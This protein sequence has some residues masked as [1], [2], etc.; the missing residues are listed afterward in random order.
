MIKQ[1]VSSF[2]IV[3]LT[4]F[5]VFSITVFSQ[6]NEHSKTTIQGTITSL[7]STRPIANVDITVYYHEVDITK[8]N[9]PLI[10]SNKDAQEIVTL[11][12]DALGEFECTIPLRK[13]TDYVFIKITGSGYEPIT[14]NLIKIKPGDVQEHNFTLT[15]LHPT[16]EEE[17]LIENKTKTFRQQ[18]QIEKSL[19]LNPTELTTGKKK[20]LV[21]FGLS[22]QSS[23]SACSYLVPTSVFVSN[24]HNGYNG[25]SNGNGYTGYIDFDLYVAGVVH[26]EIGGITTNIE[27]K[28]AQAIAARTFSLNRHEQNLPVNIGQAYHDTPTESSSLGSFQSSEQVI[29]YN[30]QVIDAKYSAR[31]NGDYTQAATAGTWSPYTTCD[32]YGNEIP[33]LQSVSCSG[34]INCSQTSEIP[35]CN[36]TISTS[37]ELGYIYGH[38]VGMCQRGIEQFGEI[39][40]WSACQMLT[41]Y[42]TGVCIANTNCGNSSSTLICENA[43]PIACGQSY[44]GATSNATSNVY[45]YGCNNWTETGPERVHQITP[46]VSGILT[47]TISNFTGDLDVYLL[48]SCDPFDCLGTVY[49]AEVIFEH[50]IADSTYYIVVDADDGSGSGYNLMVQCEPTTQVNDKEKPNKITIYPNPTN[51]VLYVAGANN[52]NAVIVKNTQGKTV[53]T[54]KLTHGK[55]NLSSLAEGIY[56]VQILGEELQFSRTII[57]Q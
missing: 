10:T 13:V 5:M 2:K 22:A 19:D 28:K 26:G 41:N 53:L 38:G 43:I 35:C 29:L 36:A 51:D 31:C 50:A 40:G 46:S 14:K 12:S 24:L 21:K 32:T 48:G 47:A 30:N 55:I 27:T 20:A 39:F 6:N 3:M 56:L 9:Y 4:I 11:K 54:A 42:Y 18:V 8:D 44:T 52:K 23:D 49:S 7:I 15:P 33:Y 1:L 34:H 25:T 57:K 16:A 37:Q 45:S 17:L